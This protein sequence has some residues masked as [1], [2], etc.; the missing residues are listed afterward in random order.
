MLHALVLSDEQIQTYGSLLTQLDPADLDFTHDEYYEACQE[1][2]AS[3]G[4]EF[5]HDG[6][7]FS[8]HYSA[9]KERL[10]FF[11]VP[12]ESGWS[13]TVN[14]QAVPVEKVSVGFMAVKVPAGESDIRFEYRT[15]G[16]GEGFAMSGAALVLLVLYHRLTLC[17]D[18][19]LQKDR[20]RRIF[21]IKSSENGAA[22]E[23][24]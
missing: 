20:K 18:N 8:L 11:S 2:R 3:A 17:M 7:G 5:S 10:V 4:T 15:P 24:L 22:E 21:R 14:G 16:L 1:R 12:Y 13:A 23:E 6:T 9:E 19:R